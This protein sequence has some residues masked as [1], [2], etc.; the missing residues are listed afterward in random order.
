M[1]ARSD[2]ITV[3]REGQMIATGLA[4]GSIIK[5]TV[6]G[7]DMISSL[8]FNDGTVWKKVE[9]IYFDPIT[10]ILKVVYHAD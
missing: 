9:A 10:N 4:D 1:T 5:R 2:I 6:A 7:E 8:A 3:V